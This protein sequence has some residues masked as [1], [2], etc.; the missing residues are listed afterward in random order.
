M[1][2]PPQTYLLSFTAGSA[3]PVE[4]TTVAEEIISGKSWSEIEV[5]VLKRN[6]LRKPKLATSRREFQEIRKR[7]EALSTEELDSLLK[8]T[9]SDREGI[10]LLSMLRVYPIL[11]QFFNEVVLENLSMI[12]REFSRTDLEQFFRRKRIEHP[13]LDQLAE[14]TLAKVR[15]VILRIFAETGVIESS[16]KWVIQ[17]PLWTT[18]LIKY[19][20]EN[21]KSL[22]TFASI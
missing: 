13:E 9:K 2:A 3:L 17:K 11:R 21:E 6:L 15:Q 19:F 14:T 1:I 5:M 12:R 16:R 20:K 8:A 22:F 7:I 18:T 4:M 10:I